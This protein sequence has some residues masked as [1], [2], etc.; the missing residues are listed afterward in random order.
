MNRKFRN[1]LLGTAAMLASSSAM[2]TTY[3]LD[4]LLFSADLGNSGDQ[5][6]I[7]ALAAWL[8]I[9]SSL[10]IIDDKVDAVSGTA[11][12][13]EGTSDQWFIDVAPNEPGYFALKF[14]TG[15]TGVNSDTYYF[16]NTAELDKLVWS[17]QQVNY[18]TGGCGRNNCN[19]GRLS[20]YTLFNGNDDPNE[21]VPEPATL[22]LLGAGLAGLGWRR[23]KNG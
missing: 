8:G 17:N 11:Q 9:D 18:L 3:G 20:H 21:P 6:E 4:E 19:I 5:T 7:D 12:P 16:K 1:L 2:A 22:A 14:G 15:G 23:R 13:N 10:V